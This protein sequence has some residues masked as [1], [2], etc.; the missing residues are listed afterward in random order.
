MQ[1]KIR[2]LFK[3][4]KPRKRQK[5]RISQGFFCL[6][7]I[8]YNKRDKD[9]FLHYCQNVDNLVRQSLQVSL[10]KDLI[11]YKE[12]LQLIEKISRMSIT[13]D[14]EHSNTLSVKLSPE[15]LACQNLVNIFC[16]NYHII[17]LKIITVEEEASV[18]RKQLGILKDEFT[19]V[20]SNDLSTH[21]VG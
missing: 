14:Y 15:T 12:V 17:V 21:Q 1:F 10:S 9:L 13:G 3:F 18:L 20:L 6:I 5:H 11:D 19:K 16:A 2:F 7:E 8:Y 4:R